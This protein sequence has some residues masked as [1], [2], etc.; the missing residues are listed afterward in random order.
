MNQTKKKQKR[1][2]ILG[3]DGR[4]ERGKEEEKSRPMSFITALSVISDQLG[5]LEPNYSLTFA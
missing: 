2:G 3:C 1:G 5:T 4:K